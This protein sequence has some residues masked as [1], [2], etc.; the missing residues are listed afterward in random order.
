MLTERI[1]ASLVNH[2]PGWRVPQRTALARR[3][4]VSIAEID[5]AI[6]ELTARHLLRLLPD[7]CLY[8]ASPADYLIALEGLPGLGTRIDP[9]GASIACAARQISW[10]RIPEDIGLM[11]GLPPG[12]AASVIRCQW[13]ANGHRAALST[14]YLPD[15]PDTVNA[16]REPGPVTLDAALNHAPVTVAGTA[17][18]AFPEALHV[19]VQPPAASVARSLRLAPGIPAV[20]VAVRFSDS[21]RSY[22]VALTAAVLR[23]DLFRIIIEA[24]SGPPGHQPGGLGGSWADIAGCWQS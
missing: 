11:L 13:T 23:S 4:N 8:R 6:R 17:P 7:G 9:M 5:C 18:A 12:A 20:T 15:D 19:E 14:T 16:A 3:F 21:S 1:A 2:E 24:A 22:P 10:R